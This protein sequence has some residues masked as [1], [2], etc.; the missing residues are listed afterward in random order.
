MIVEM[1]ALEHSGTWELVLLPPGKKVIGCR[2]VYTIKV[3][4]KGE[5]DRL[6]AHLVAK[7]YTQI[8][9]LDYGGH[10]FS[11]GQDHYCSSLSCHGCHSSL[12]SSS[13]RQ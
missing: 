3:G 5:V 9:G 6:K 7:G 1:Q 13:V 10:F 4:P 12:A 11:C 8:Y 2:W